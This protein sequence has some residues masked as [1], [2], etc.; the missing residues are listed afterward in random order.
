LEGF[1]NRETATFKTMFWG[2]KKRE[3][4]YASKVLEIYSKK[5]LEQGK[6]DQP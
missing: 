1:K 2:E 6:A 3:Q 5:K 4:K